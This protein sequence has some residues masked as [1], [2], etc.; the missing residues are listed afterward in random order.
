M[1]SLSIS[2]GE[3]GSTWTELDC[4]VAALVPALVRVAQSGSS[5]VVSAMGG[6]RQKK[7]K[8]PLQDIKDKRTYLSA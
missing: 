5:Q 4:P 3:K 7:Q 6:R 8:M 1:I 2:V